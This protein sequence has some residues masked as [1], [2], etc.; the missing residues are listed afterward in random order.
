VPFTVDTVVRDEPLAPHLRMWSAV[1]EQAPRTSAA[2]ELIS[3]TET[4][5]AIY[6]AGL[7]YPTRAEASG[8]SRC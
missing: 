6:A 8:R 3:R 4:G 5:L 2:L 7:T 1:R